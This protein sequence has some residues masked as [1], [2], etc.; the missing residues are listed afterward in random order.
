MPLSLLWSKILT[1]RKK[2]YSV[3]FAESYRLQNTSGY[4]L[5]I[6]EKTL[7]S[8]L[9]H[10]FKMQV[11]NWKA[12]RIHIVNLPSQS[13]YLDD[14]HIKCR[15]NRNTEYMM[16]FFTQTLIQYPSY[17]SHIRQVRKY[18]MRKGPALKRVIFCANS[19]KESSLCVTKFVFPHSLIS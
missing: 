13:V 18:C 6:P 1:R 16:S 14:K 10:Q 3:L 2:N 4:L 15:I 9:N 17:F 12:F 7:R 19:H 11:I 8:H 5:F